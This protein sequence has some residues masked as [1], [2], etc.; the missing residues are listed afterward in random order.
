[1]KV[2]LKSATF[3]NFKKIKLL[4]VIFSYLT[5][6][7]GAN[8]TGKT[9]IFDGVLWCLFGKN[10]QDQEDF[11]IKTLDPNNN[12]L[13]KLEHEVSVYLEVDGII[14]TFRR[15][16]REKWVKKR[17]E[18]EYE[19]S[20]HETL[21][22]CNDIPLS[23]A[24]YQAKIDYIC[25]ES[26]FKMITSPS[27]FNNM[28]W[29]DRR[30]VLF[31]IAGNITNS[32][33]AIGKP[34]FEKLLLAIGNTDM[35]KYK[36]VIS[37]R[38]KKLKEDLE[39]I[40]TRID[41]INRNMPEIKDWE[42]IN[43]DIDGKRFELIGIEKQLA[44]ISEAYKAANQKQLDKQNQIFT[45]K[46]QIQEIEF[47]AKFEQDKSKNNRDREISNLKRSIED[48]QVE[49][50]R[51][52]NCIKDNNVK[53]E[54]LG[55]DRQ[56]LLSDWHDEDQ[57]QLVFEDDQFNCPTCNRPFEADDIEAKKAEMHIS[58]SD[59]KK[60]KLDQIS[61]S[62]KQ[63]KSSIEKFNSENTTSENSISAI[64]KEIA[65][66]THR[67]NEYQK[68]EA[69]LIQPEVDLTSNSEYQELKTKLSV[70]ESG[71]IEMSKIDN[72]ELIQKKNNLTAEIDE[73]N[74]QISLKTVID[75][76]NTRLEELARQEKSLA[77][78]IADMEM[79]EFTIKDF[80]RAKIEAVEEKINSKF[81]Y[82][83][84]KMYNEQI[85]GGQEEICETLYNGVPYSDLNTA[86]KILAGL[87]IINALSKHY[88]VYCP[89]FLDN[90]ESTT[91]IPEMDCQI[92]NL[93]VSPEDKNL[94]IA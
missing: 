69:L 44:D 33:I 73:L 19:F 62:G 76:N 71:S 22:F 37:S 66:L 55:N 4:E 29:Q 65:V 46:R 54:K 11:N 79:I 18:P 36:K 51:L 2:N 50:T 3:I 70:M 67:L 27:Y 57:K 28:K 60:K 59:N 8:E 86:G 48:K 1:M 81:K 75:Q 10:S 94:R 16:F 30:S 77:Q 93:Y 32:D 92:I 61:S 87:D 24:E 21:Y 7:F 49:L 23:Q 43:I 88:D 64:N 5:N 83:K 84:F 41:E 82:V 31:E 42:T 6:I 14:S 78:Q 20:G 15:V 47:N 39:A 58:F 74:K 85:N 17:G 34:E 80:T 35:V 91:E 26:T 89:I 53:I 90:R 12:A 9:T 52:K 63:V 38:K 45:I 72:A 68:P 25:K 13:P 40:P 56:K